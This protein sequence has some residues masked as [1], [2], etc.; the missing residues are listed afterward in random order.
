MRKKPGK[1]ASEIIYN[2][3]WR[4]CY[5]FARM[6]LNTDQYSAPGKNEKFMSS[7][8]N[9]LEPLMLLDTITEND[10]YKICRDTLMNNLQKF[11]EGESKSAMQ[12]K[13][14]VKTLTA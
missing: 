14:S 7:L 6:M 13:F 8:V 1:K 10:K 12:R 11:S 4:N 9:E 2:S 5:W 3:A